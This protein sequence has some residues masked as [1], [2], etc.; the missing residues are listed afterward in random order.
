VLIR[1]SFARDGIDGTVKRQ[2]LATYANVN[3]VS[4]ALVSE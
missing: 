3:D 1:H 4:S 2:E